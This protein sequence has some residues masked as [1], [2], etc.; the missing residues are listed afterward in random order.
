[1]RILVSNDD[2]VKSEGLWALAQALRPLGEVVVVAPDRERS[3]VGHSLTFFSPLRV[4]E[5]HQ[6]DGFA[7]YSSDGTP[8]DC[9][10]LGI[11]DLMLPQGPDLVV[12]GINHGA[13]LGDDLTYS[14]TV[15]AA[16][17]GVIHG[18]PA[19]A[20]S[21]AAIEEPRY[22]VAAQFAARLAARVHKKKLPPKT[23]LNVNVPNVAPDEIQGVWITR[24]GESIYDQRLIKRTDPRGNEY[25]WITGSLPTGEPLDGT[26]FEA[27]F[28]NRISV[29]P[30]QLNMTNSAFMKK[31]R[32]WNL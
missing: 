15:S 29:T 18:I 22:D 3:A 11:Y 28:S 17:E 27:V 16:M 19:I 9:V 30:V 2:G 32:A 7:V 31:L 23:I 24:Q 1:M 4:E 13:N 25:Y 21:L 26:D 12:S 5:V 8:T 6:E 14:G 20:I 10:V